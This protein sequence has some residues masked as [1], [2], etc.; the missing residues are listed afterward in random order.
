M[1]NFERAFNDLLE[2]EGGFTVDKGGRTNLGITET[3]ARRHG[4]SGDMKDL[5]IETARS[6]YHSEYWNPF[7]D[8][9]SYPVA[10]QLFDA[11]VNSGPIQSHKW[12]QRVVGVKDD[13]VIGP[14]TKEAVLNFNSIKLIVMF[15]VLR[16]EFMTGLSNWPQAGKGWTRRIA[17]NLR[18]GFEV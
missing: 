16:L 8:Q 14:K 4:Y 2:V 11:A 3:T 9:L 7:Y 5:P 17:K 18:K 10:Y 6:I 12:L 13:G 1:T 15:N